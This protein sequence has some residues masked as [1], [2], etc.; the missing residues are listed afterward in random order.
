VGDDVLEKMVTIH[1]YRGGT[2]KTILSLNLAGVFAS[3]GKRVCLIDFDLRA[4]TL[5]VA[6]G[7]PGV[8][9]WINNYLNR[10]C[11]FLETLVDVTPRFKLKGE[12]S[13]S[14][15]NPSV[16]AIRQMYEKSRK[17]ELEALKRL[18]ELK[19][20][21]ETKTKFDYCIID[22]S[23]GLYYTSLNAIIAADLAI[24]VTTPD[25]SDVEGT[26]KMMKEFYDVFGKN[27]AIVV[28][29]VVGGGLFTDQ[30]AEKQVEHYQ[31]VY[32]RTILGVAPCFCELAASGRVG[33]FVADK[34]RH[35]FSRFIKII[36]ARIE[37]FKVE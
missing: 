11:D 37:A 12:L 20:T 2:G 33:L 27:T 1:S 26:K 10:E 4:P 5:H 23:P 21:L 9:K 17:W 15:A 14:F 7:Q 13:V 24:I 28:N 22:T 8:E 19:R 30:E 3:Y 34:P 29:K 25:E 16:E 32:N 18:L 6:L 35:P 31:Q 36:A